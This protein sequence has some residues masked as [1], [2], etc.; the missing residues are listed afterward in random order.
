MSA[1]KLGIILFSGFLLFATA[2]LGSAQYNQDKDTSKKQTTTQKDTTASKD[3]GKTTTS[4]TQSTTDKAK[5][6]TAKKATARKST[7]DKSAV[8]QKSTTDK[9]DAKKATG[10]KKTSGL[11]RDKV[12]QAQTD[13][14]D[15]GFD[16]GPIDGIMGVKTAAALRNFQ[17]HNHLQVS[18]NLN[19]E[20]ESALKNGVTASN[21]TSENFSNKNVSDYL[22]DAGDIQQIQIALLDL[23]YDAGDV[24]GMLSS[25]TQEAIR[26]FQWWNDLP[27]TGNAD[28]QTWAAINA[29]E[30]APVENA[31]LTQTAPISSEL[32]SDLE[33]DLNSDQGREKPTISEGDNNV[34][35]SGKSGKVDKDASERISKAAAVLQDR[36]SAS[37]KRVPNE[38]LQR[39]EAIAVIPNMVK[40]AFGIGGRFG[41]GVVSERAENG[42]WSAPAFIE[43]G[44]GSFGLQIGVSSTDLV[45]VFTDRKAM[46]MLEG[47]KDLKLGVDAGVVAGPLG[48]EAEA[49][50][51]AK[52]ETAIYA[53]SRSKGLFAGIA[54][55]GAVLNMDKD[56]NAK[57]YGSS[58]DARQILGGSTASNTTVRPFID[59]LDK[60]VPKKRY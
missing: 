28:Q 35:K 15:A 37:D 58:G 4:D 46:S 23:G 60:V 18:G 39:A 6:K 38:L 49:G 42:R 56:M 55:D 30:N 5:S 36:T 3:T 31:A 21:R 19:S 10:T 2:P 57:V 32:K 8:D 12:R 17:S 7:T 52:L 9:T 40:G 54:L 29:Q 33:S 27:V 47:G 34:S 16:P 26:Q 43:I 13:L 25:Q 1:N 59:A 20:T 50:V 53:Y 14:K 22:S 41:K 45:L 44:G 11:S 24:N 51:N 48:R